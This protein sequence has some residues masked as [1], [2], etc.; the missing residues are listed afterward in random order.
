MIYDLRLPLINPHMQG[1]TIEFIHAEPGP[2]KAG[3]KL[4]DISIDLGS[5][6]AQECPPISFYRLVTR[7]AAWLAQTDLAPGQFLACGDLLATFTTEPDE[8]VA[9]PV[10]R[11]LRYTIA[12]IM[13][14]DRMWTGGI[15]A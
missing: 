11:A 4:V 10:A 12:G 3:A 9:Q 2:L 15:T 14:H 13:H 8:P 6:F 7:E 1:A 5:A